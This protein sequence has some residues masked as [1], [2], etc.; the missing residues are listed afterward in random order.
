MRSKFNFNFKKIIKNMPALTAGVFC[1][2]LLWIFTGTSCYIRAVF[3][4]PC[5]GCGSTRALFSLFRGD[6]KQSFEYHPLILLTLVLILGYILITVFDIK[7]FDKFNKKNINI[8][9][10]CVFIIYIVVYIIRMILFFPNYEPMT[11]LDTSIFG[12]IIGF[13]KNII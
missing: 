4:I 9:L 8:F 5:P 12:R 10:W 11:Y 2:I 6:I 1:W 3:G 7:I 13:V